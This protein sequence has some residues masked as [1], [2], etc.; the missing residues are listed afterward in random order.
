MRKIST[1]ASL[2]V[3]AISM[4]IASCSNEEGME[5]PNMTNT[6]Q[7]TRSQ[8]VDILKGMN[9]DNALSQE[10]HE[11]VTNSLASGRDE[12]VRFAD[13]LASGTRANGHSLFAAQLTNILQDKSTTRSAEGEDIL[14]LLGYSDFII[15]WPY[16]EDWDGKELPTLVAAPDDDDALEAMGTKIVSDENGLRYEEVLV[17]E[18]YTMQHPVWVINTKVEK[19]GVVYVTKSDAED[20]S[21]NV[22]QFATRAGAD[23]IYVWRLKKMQVTHQYDGPFKGGPDIEMHISYPIS[24]GSVNSSTIHQINFSRK[25]VKNKRWKELNLILNSDWTKNQIDNGIFIL[26]Q[27]WDGVKDDITAN[28][29]LSY[30]DDNGFSSSVTAT[31]KY[32]KHDEF[33]G[34][35]VLKRSYMLYNSE[36]TYD[37]NRVNIIAPIE[38]EIH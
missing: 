8:I 37:N 38:V 9:Y 19:T 6:Q 23:T 34:K 18:E 14:K 7:I 28:L 2:L 1:L 13:L 15:Y 17:D 16:S 29:A 25:D 31:I 30:Q 22:P 12:Y 36:L 4:T 24:A 20:E 21:I 5:T 32:T 35:Q 3:L 33:I 26:E 27:D 11:Y 10:I